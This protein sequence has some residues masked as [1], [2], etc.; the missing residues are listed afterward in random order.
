MGGLAGGVERFVWRMG[1]GAEVIGVQAEDG[2]K[3]E[4]GAGGEED[5]EGFNKAK[6]HQPEVEK[7][8]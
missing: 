3:P 8:D 2:S 1:K 5:A 6:S 4:R 7:R